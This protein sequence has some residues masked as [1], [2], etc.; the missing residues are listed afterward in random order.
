MLLE[1][2]AVLR[3]PELVPIRYGRMMASPFTFFRGA[4]L[5]MASDLST[6]PNSGIMTQL[7]GDA[8]LS[9]FGVFGT[10]ERK[11][12]FDIN[13]F[14]ETLPG[15]WEWDV[16]RLA[17][18]FEVG[19]RNAGFTAQQR[20]ETT[21]AVAE[22]YRKQMRGAAKARVLDAWYDRLDADRILSWVRAETEAKRAGKRQVK[23]AQAI[24]A[25]ARTKDSVAV[26]A[27]LVR[28]VDGELRIQADPPL[29]E[30]L[31]DLIGDV[32]ARSRLEDSMRMLLQE[33]ATTL[34]FENHPVKEFSF[35]HMARKVV[36]VGS[37]G[38]RAWILLLR[39]RDD[40]DPLVLQAKEAQESV[41][42]RYLGPSLYPSHGQRVVEGQRLLQASGDIF[43]G[44]QSV[45]GIDGVARD[46]YIRQLHDW[47][48][49][50][51]VD[52]IRPRGAKF[53]ASMCGQALARAHA[54]AG[55]RM[56]IA[57]YLGKGSRFD[58]AIATFSSAYAE[59]NE[60][61]YEAFV[62]AVTSG[63]IQ[64]VTGI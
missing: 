29:V 28:E 52:D 21:L 35:V 41:L 63:R 62:S 5:L 14:D 50:V 11:L 8:H 23:K 26:F 55:D 13:D 17:A 1:G 15:P 39:G 58:E 61:D 49:S 34:A 56:A 40:G 54:R 42:E 45:E 9:N 30:P 10:A 27:K 6:T 48:G 20:H 51:D 31:E 4:A 64:A 32:A 18:S 2:Q 43:L 57:A 47:K 19:T 16:K 60:R 53:Y 33:Y 59:Q 22:G 7:C 12:V 25:K 3:V 37:V 46:F 24:M 36:G 38:T 44:W